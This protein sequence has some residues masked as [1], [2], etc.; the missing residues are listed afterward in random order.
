MKNHKLPQRFV[1]R[2]KA[3]FPKEMGLHNILKRNFE[4]IPIIEQYLK[5]KSEI[6][7]DPEEIISLIK[8]GGVQELYKRAIH[9]VHRKKLYKESR[10]MLLAIMFKK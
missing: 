5:E 10:H 9:I 8:K 4:L 7:I 1:Q 3:E 2:V 6:V